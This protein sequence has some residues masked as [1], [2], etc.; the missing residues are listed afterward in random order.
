VN[1]IFCQILNNNNNKHIY[2]SRQVI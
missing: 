1:I 2:Y